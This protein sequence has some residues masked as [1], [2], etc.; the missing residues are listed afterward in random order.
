MTQF[1]NDLGLISLLGIKNVEGQKGTFND[2]INVWEPDIYVE[3]EI[4][5]YKLG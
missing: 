2:H 1:P 4:K 3:L 5:E